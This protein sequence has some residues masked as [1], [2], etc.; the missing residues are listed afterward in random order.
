ME[1]FLLVVISSMFAYLLFGLG[2]A[3]EAV[4]AAVRRHRTLTA[5]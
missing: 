2:K 3:T 1:V 5:N 4:A